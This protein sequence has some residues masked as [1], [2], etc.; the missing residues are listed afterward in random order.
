MEKKKEDKKKD[1]KKET[2]QETEKTKDKL[3]KK[4]LPKKKKRKISPFTYICV[5]FD[6]LVIIFLFVVYGP[7]KEFK[8]W[9]ITTA[10]ASGHHQYFANV[11]YSERDIERALKDNIVIETNDNTNV[12]EITFENTEKDSY[13]SIYEEQILKRDEGNDLYKVVE[14]EEK[15]YKGFLVV[16]YDAKR[17]SLVNARYGGQTLVNI[18]K[19]NNAKVAINASGFSYSTGREIPTGTVIQNGKVASVGGRNRHGGGLIGF[20]KDGVLMLTSDSATTAIKNGMWNAMTFGPFL[21]VNGKSAKVKGNGGWGVANRTAIAQRK[22]GIVL[23]LVI[24]GRGANGSDGISI[25]D[26]IT[27]L[28]KY[29]A[30]NAANL[31]GGGSST[32]VINNKLINNPRGY[33]YVGERKIPNGWIVK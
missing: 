1:K 3:E 22:D 21:I 2:K 19:Y 7:S 30:Y 13:E 12:D 6:L 17:I 20:T 10:L 9:F 24:D 33:G 23:F 8:N 4:E 27:L 11:L 18:A 15:D 14:I 25:K 32:L 16:I 5:F 31:D 28:E 26:M 29:K